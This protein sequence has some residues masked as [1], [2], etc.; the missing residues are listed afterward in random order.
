[1][2]ATVMGR[3]RVRFTLSPGSLC[4]TGSEE[5]AE[6][7]Q[8]RWR[9]ALVLGAFTLIAAFFIAVLQL[10]DGL[11]WILAAATV[12][13]LC[14]VVIYLSIHA[15]EDRSRPRPPMRAHRWSNDT[16]ARGYERPVTRITT[17]RSRVH[18]TSDA[19]YTRLAPSPKLRHDTTILAIPV[20]FHQFLMLALVYIAG[21]ATAIALGDELSGGR[22]SAIR[23]A[24]SQEG[25]V[26]VGPNNVGQFLRLDTISGGYLLIAIIAF[27]ASYWL[28]RRGGGGHLFVIGNLLAAPAILLGG[29]AA[30]SVVVQ[31]AILLLAIVFDLFL[32]LLGSS[33]F[34]S[35]SSV[36]EELILLEMLA[37]VV[38][39]AVYWILC[40]ASVAATSLVVKPLRR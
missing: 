40:Q 31:V 24:V 35:T 22:S 38:V 16:L 17:K 25:L 4:G 14:E 29:I 5:S 15:R 2:L 13:A 11:L 6:V 9:T 10:Q 26:V 39:C 32:A 18:R 8:A 28:T 30:L 7:D 33:G 21:N 23:D 27:I 37:I 3:R 12:A 1:M 19:N 20:A 36:F 34:I